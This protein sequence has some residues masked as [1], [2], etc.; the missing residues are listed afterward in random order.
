MTIKVGCCDW[1][2]P[3]FKIGFHSLFE[4]AFDS[5]NSI[6]RVGF[7]RQALELPRSARVAPPPNRTVKRP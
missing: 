1:N 2:Q 3:T 6:G 5:V 4:F 7:H